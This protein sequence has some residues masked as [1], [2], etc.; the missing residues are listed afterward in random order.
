MSNKNNNELTEDVLKNVV[1]GF[2]SGDNDDLTET[3][4]DDDDVYEK[5]LRR[6]RRSTD[7]DTIIQVLRDREHY[8]KPSVRRNSKADRIRSKKTN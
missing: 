1:G 2:D 5:S 8:S 7:H 6:F 4:S 3:P